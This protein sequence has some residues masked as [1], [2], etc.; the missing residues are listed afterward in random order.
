[1]VQCMRIDSKDT[2]SFGG[3]LLRQYF[4]SALYVQ[5]CVFYGKSPGSINVSQ[6]VNSQDLCLLKAFTT[7]SQC[8]MTGGK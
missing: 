6:S 5:R 2:L 1:M 3:D 4:N 7:T 8:I